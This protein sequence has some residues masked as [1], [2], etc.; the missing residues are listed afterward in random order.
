MIIA[1]FIVIKVNY[2]IDEAR[3]YGARAAAAEAYGRGRR[4]MMLF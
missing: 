1:L 4:L 2:K 3:T